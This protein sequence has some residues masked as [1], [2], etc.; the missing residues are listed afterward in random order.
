MAPG[1]KRVVSRAAELLI[2]GKFLDL[3]NAIMHD[4]QSI[5]LGLV[6]KVCTPSM[7]VLLATTGSGTTNSLLLA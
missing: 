3:G 6:A 1:F 4:V 2:P 7:Y 5:N